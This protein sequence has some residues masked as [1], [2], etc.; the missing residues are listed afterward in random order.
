MVNEKESE[1]RLFVAMNSPLPTHVI[2]F[3]S[4]EES[5]TITSPESF[6]AILN[7]TPSISFSEVTVDIVSFLSFTFT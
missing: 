4:G 2:P 7:L 5:L 1:R 6:F 3:N